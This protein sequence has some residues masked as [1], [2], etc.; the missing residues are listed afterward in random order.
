MADSFEL[1]SPLTIFITGTFMCSSSIVSSQASQVE[2][3]L[4]IKIFN[5]KEPQQKK[6][7]DDTFNK[8]HRHEVVVLILVEFKLNH[9]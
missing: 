9:I 7:A 6:F 8:R 5:K 3:W 4:E 2:K 1:R